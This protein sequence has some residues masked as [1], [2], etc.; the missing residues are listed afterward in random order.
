[1][2]LLF[3]LRFSL[4]PASNTEN[5]SEPGTPSKRA[6]AKTKKGT[7]TPSKRTKKVA[8]FDDDD[9]EDGEVTTLSRKKARVS[10]VKGSVDDEI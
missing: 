4:T 1:M 5:G 6:T 8:Q 9:D 10:P 7:A 2:F 3:L